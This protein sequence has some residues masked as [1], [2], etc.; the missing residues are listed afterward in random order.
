MSQKADFVSLEEDSPLTF[1]F[2]RMV[3]GSTTIRD[4]ETHTEK[5]IPSLTLHVIELDFDPVDTHLSFVSKRAILMLKTLRARGVLFSR[6][7]QITKTGKGFQTQYSFD[8]L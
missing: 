5:T 2:D 4:T 1:K 7:I 8:I 6:P 3:S